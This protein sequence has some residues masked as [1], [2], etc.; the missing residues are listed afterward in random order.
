MD[1]YCWQW[2]TRPDFSSERA[3]PQRQMINLQTELISGHKSYSGLDTKTYW[4][5]VS[6]NVTSTSK[7]EYCRMEADQNTSTVALS[8]VRSDE[9]GTQCQG[10]CLGHP[11]PGGFGDLGL[12]VGGVSNETAKYVL[13][14]STREWLLWRGPETIVRVSFRS[15]L[16]S[17]TALGIKKHAIVKQETKIYSSAPYGSPTPRKTGQLTVDRNLTSTSKRE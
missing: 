4:L 9:K 2:L 12:Q 11:I 7:R 10:V 13:R 3:P 1:K 6:R 15:I 16:S 14:D 17:D 5:T 8:V